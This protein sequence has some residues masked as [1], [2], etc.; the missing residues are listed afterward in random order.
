MKKIIIQYA[1]KNKKLEYV[2]SF[3]YYINDKKVTLLQFYKSQEEVEK[4]KEYYFFINS[5]FSTL[6]FNK[7]IDLNRLSY[8]DKFE[9]FKSN[10]IKPIFDSGK[11]YYYKMPNVA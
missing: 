8:E 9:Y 11:Y 5:C 6:Q 1:K 3:A 4:N 2:G 7:Q 10:K